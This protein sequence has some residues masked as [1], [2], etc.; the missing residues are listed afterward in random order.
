MLQLSNLKGRDSSNEGG[1][2]NLKK[3]N[4]DQGCW[5]NGS[6]HNSNCDINLEISRTPAASF[7]IN[8]RNFFPSTNLRPSNVTQLLQG[9]SRSDIQGLKLDHHHHQMVQEESFCN[10][11]NAGINED[12]Q[13]FWPWPDQHHQFQ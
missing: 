10:M 3:D 2:S 11:F 9:S 6:D 12:H 7:Q 8:G 13:G 4:E 1:F 5:S